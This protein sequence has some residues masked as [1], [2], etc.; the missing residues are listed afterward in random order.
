M[1]FAYEGAG[2]RTYL[3]MLILFSLI[4]PLW[5]GL[6]IL[7]PWLGGK[8]S[9]AHMSHGNRSSSEGGS[10]AE[11]KELISSTMNKNYWLENQSSD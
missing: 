3:P 10:T 2:K 11:K 5:L 7:Y 6:L 1:D 4:F 9:R 8:H